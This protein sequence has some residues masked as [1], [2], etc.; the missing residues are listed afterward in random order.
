MPD[1]DFR[2]VFGDDWHQPVLNLARYYGKHFGCRM[3]RSGV[4]VPESLRTFLDGAIDMPDA[5]MALV[6]TDSVHKR[7]KAGLSISP[8]FATTDATGNRFTSYVVAAYIGSIG[9]RYAWY[10][11]GLE[12]RSQFFHYPHPAINRGCPGLRGSL[13]WRSPA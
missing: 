4:P 7:Y 5:H 8:D 3:V 6:T 11:S 9:I 12:E 13:R 10:E 2:D 1:V